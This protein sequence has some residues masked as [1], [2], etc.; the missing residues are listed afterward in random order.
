MRR[1]LSVLAV[2]GLYNLVQNGLGAQALRREFVRSYLRVPQDRPVRIL[3]VGCGTAE[4]L[5]HL[6]E[7]AYVG[8]DS[9]RPYIEAARTRF[10]GRGEFLCTDATSASFTERHGRFDLAV[11][12]GLQHHLSDEELVRVLV[13]V[14]RAL[15]PGGR[16]VTI[17]PTWND[18]TPAIGRFLAKRDRGEHVR[19]PEA[20]RRLAGEAYRHVCMHVRHDLLRVPYSHAILECA[21]PRT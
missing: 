3:D 15:E 16:L 14:G 9:S 12:T 6:P 1:L 18:E 7:C 11:M 19:A 4:L 2:P 8:V 10:G 13:S 20:Y 5:P 17:D 21:E